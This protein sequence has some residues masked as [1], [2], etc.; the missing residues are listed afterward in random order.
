MNNHS[1]SVVSVN[2]S[3]VG[4]VFIYSY[5]VRFSIDSLK[6]RQMT[7]KIIITRIIPAPILVF[8]TDTPSN[9]Y[10]V[11]SN[12]L[13]TP[14]ICPPKSS[15]PPVI[16]SPTGK[17]VSLAKSVIVVKYGNILNPNTPPPTYKTQG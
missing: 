5:L 11:I 13:A 14:K 6:C 16:A 12:A 4:L 1:L 7:P 10:T 9:T 3:A 8:V 2:R 17:D 15:D